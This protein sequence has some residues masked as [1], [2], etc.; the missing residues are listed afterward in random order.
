MLQFYFKIILTIFL[1]QEINRI[2]LNLVK[3]IG[4]SVPDNSYCPSLFQEHLW[5]LV[6]N[7][8]NA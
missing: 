6:E 5:G 7:S 8:I 4:C 2:I 3:N 1:H